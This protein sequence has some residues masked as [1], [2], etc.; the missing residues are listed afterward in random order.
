MLLTQ[1]PDATFPARADVVVIGG[2]VVG[3][4]A[5][6]FLARAGVSVVL[7]EK[8]RVAAEQ[9]SRNW[10][11][12]RKQGRDPIELP[13]MIE[14]EREWKSIAAPIAKEIRMAVVGTT[15]LAMDD[16][17]FAARRDWV[18]SAR[19]FQLDCKV[20]GSA[21]TDALLGRDDRRFKGAIHTA[22]DMTAEPGLAVPALGRLAR[23]AGATLI[24]GC[25]ARGVERSG[26]R[27]SHVVTERGAIACDSVILGGGAWSRTF[28]ENMG[29]F[30]PQLGVR[31]TVLRTTPGPEIHPGG[32]GATSASLRRRGDGG[33]TI[34]RTHAARFDLIPAA[35][36]H[37]RAYIPQMKLRWNTM[38][39][40]AG[41]EFFGDLGHGRWSLD[42]E[43]PFERTRVLDPAP[44]TALARN[45]LTSAKA[46]HPQ[47]G[48]IQ[49]AGTWAG[50]IDVTPD[51][52]PIIDEMPGCA[53]LWV[54][55]GLSGHGFGIGPGVGR[56]VAELATAR[57]PIVDTAPFALSRFAA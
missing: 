48:N 41:A 6:L 42:Q 11:W 24:E 7:V 31:S 29:I 26:G 2:G 56:V 25:A 57:N 43:S 37:F 38:Q 19:G 53:G 21:E 28:L 17:E 40:R 3:V 15:Y 4:T 55:T 51:E 14:S 12:I 18:E 49:I 20:L 45:M 52:L 39:L 54:A 5:A 33:Y 44:N 10:G 32:L 13:L 47:L 35:F 36:R 1:D 9:S 16:T 50:M 22:S 46:L 30:I 8:G 27:V 23:E 34:G